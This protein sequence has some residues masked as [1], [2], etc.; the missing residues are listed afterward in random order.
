MAN[1]QKPDFQQEQARLLAQQ[2][3]QTRLQSQN[4]QAPEE[5]TLGR[6]SLTP[7]RFL[8]TRI[9]RN[10]AQ[11]KGGIT[12]TVTSPVSSATQLASAQAL[13]TAWLLLI[14]SWGLS[15]FYLNAHLIARLVEPKLFCQMGTEWAIGLM[16]YGPKN[17]S[18]ASSWAEYALLAVVN[19][20]YITIILGLIALVAVIGQIIISPS[21][22]AVEFL[23]WL[24]SPF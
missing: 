5:E 3:N 19:I 18:N 20:I 16:K 22:V 14:P 11:S 9:L 24:S 10:R 21:M 6:T 13:R 4:E 15:I 12:Q 7:G 1:N 17:L 2:K 23:G 8:R